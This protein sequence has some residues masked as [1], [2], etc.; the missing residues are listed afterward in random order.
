MAQP[1]ADVAWEWLLAHSGWLYAVIALVAAWYTGK[2][3]VRLFG[4]RIARRFKRPSVTRTVLRLVRT[5]ALVVGVLAAMNLLGVPITNIALS[6]TVFS[7]VL[8]LVLAPIVGSVVN[9]LFVLADQPYEIGDMVEFTQQGQRGFVEDITL[10]YTKIFTLDN[11]FLVIPNS[12][13]RE[14]DVVNHS[15]EDE[16][17]RLS[18][19]VG[20]TYESDVDA[21]R[22]LVEEA[23]ANVDGVI[24][25]G[26]AIRIGSARFPAAPQCNIDQFGESSIDLKLRFWARE[27]YRLPTLR[28][29]V[30]DAIWER[31]ESTENVDIAYPHRHH[32][33]DETSGDLSVRREE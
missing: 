4:R 22:E 3:L 2:L 19:D 29:R 1:S 28:S 7:A 10:R 25:S 13:I 20:V 9:G 18:I 16:R 30:Q 23:A 26:P 24:A 27:P 32:V 15:A 6:V 11:T 33:F 17:T 5:A 21:A 12:V 31:F 14:R 8:G